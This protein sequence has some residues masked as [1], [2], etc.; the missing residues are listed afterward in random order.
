VQLEV[1][2]SDLNACCSNICLVGDTETIKIER[3]LT[4]KGPKSAVT[5]S[6]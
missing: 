4:G 3:E 2:D 6:S 5:H 1:T